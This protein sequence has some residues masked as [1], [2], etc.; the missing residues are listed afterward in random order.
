MSILQVFSI[1]QAFTGNFGV[2]AISL[3]CDFINRREEQS[4]REHNL[5]VREHNLKIEFF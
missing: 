1:F 4:L 3:G 5:R 2:A